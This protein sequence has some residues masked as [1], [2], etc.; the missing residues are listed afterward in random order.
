MVNL[1]I[2]AFLVLSTLSLSSLN[3]L[4]AGI[5]VKVPGYG[6]IDQSEIKVTHR[7]PGKLYQLY[8]LKKTNWFFKK[9]TRSFKIRNKKSFQPFKGR[10]V[11]KIKPRWRNLQR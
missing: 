8:R 6:V 9:F 10:L 7:E 5:R 2:T 1:S 11:D 4:R 3:A